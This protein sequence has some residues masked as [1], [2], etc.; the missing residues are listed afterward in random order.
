M[1][2][3][4]SHFIVQKL[5]NHVI[6]VESRWELQKQRVIAM[7]AHTAHHHYHI[8]VLCMVSVSKV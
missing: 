8:I 6:I 3:V 2:C 4:C 7:D 1:V 5:A